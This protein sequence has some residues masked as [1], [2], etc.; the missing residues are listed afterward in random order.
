MPSL[1]TAGTI[2]HSNVPTLPMN[3]GGQ[4]NIAVEDCA[5]QL[6]PL[7]LSISVLN[8]FIRMIVKKDIGT[9]SDDSGSI[10]KDT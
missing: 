3:L 9:S 4:C 2:A 7:L 10:C 8:A 6:Q 5:T 1:V